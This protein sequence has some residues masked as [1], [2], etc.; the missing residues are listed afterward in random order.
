MT[1]EEIYLKDDISARAYNTCIDNQI[2]TVSE[3][4]EIYALNGSFDI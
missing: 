2:Y 1:L 4:K 3:L